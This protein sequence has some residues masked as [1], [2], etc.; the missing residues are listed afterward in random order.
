VS[1]KAAYDRLDRMIKEDIDNKAAANSKA[2][3]K[4]AK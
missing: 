2:E 3:R 4:K 1:R